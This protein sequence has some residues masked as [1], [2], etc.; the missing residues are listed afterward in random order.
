MLLKVIQL[1][2]VLCASLDAGL[3]F[4]TQGGLIVV[5]FAL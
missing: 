4:I 3:Q 2:G 1:V 5:Q